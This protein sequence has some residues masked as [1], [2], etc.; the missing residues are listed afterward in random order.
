MKVTQEK[1]TNLVFAEFFQVL[2]ELAYNTLIKGEIEYNDAVLSKYLD[3]VSQHL[4]NIK[5][6]SQ[7]LLEDLV[8]AVPLFNKEGLQYRWSHK[9]FQEYFAAEY[10]CRDNKGKEVDIIRTL[11]KNSKSQKY[12]FVLSLCYEIDFKTFREAL[13]IPYL[14]EFIK[15]YENSFKALIKK[16]FNLVE[17]NKRKVLCFKRIHLIEP[18]KNIEVL[19]Q[20]LNILND[21]YENQKNF[22]SRL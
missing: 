20:F 21:D 13:I 7:D 16:G 22:L 19:L 9:S 6:K 5:F 15:Y 2:R 14:N 8:K 18:Q 4:P 3:N 11:N 12:N 17:V 10:I 1:K